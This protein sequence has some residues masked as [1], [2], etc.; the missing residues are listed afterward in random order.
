MSTPENERQYGAH[1]FD[2]EHSTEEPIERTQ[3]GRE[4]TDLVDDLEDQVTAE[5]ESQGVPGNAAERA[6]TIPV[7]TGEAEPD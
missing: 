7:E 5:R 6:D 2:R 4:L 1:G 3:H